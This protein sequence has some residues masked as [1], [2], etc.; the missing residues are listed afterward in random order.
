MNDFERDLLA[1]LARGVRFV[2]LDQVARGWFVGQQTAHLQARRRVNR[3]CRAGWLHQH[4]V[5]ARPIEKLRAPCVV[6]RHDLPTADFRQLARWLHRRAQR[7]AIST[8]IV[9]ATHRSRILWGHGTRG[10][11]I[12]LTQMT[13]DLHVAEIFLRYRERGLPLDSWLSEDRLPRSW[14][15]RVKPDALLINSHGDFLRAIE[16]GGDYSSERLLALHRELARWP[17]PYEI[18]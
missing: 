3:L 6:W 2:S 9:V 12:K 17:L 15:L 5:L 1:C 13:H 4:T 14:A 18:W 10:A 7:S 8:N 11:K 16:Y